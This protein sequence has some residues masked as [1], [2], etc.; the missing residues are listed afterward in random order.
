MGIEKSYQWR[1]VAE[2]LGLIIDVNSADCFIFNLNSV[3]YVATT[4]NPDSIYLLLQ[5]AK[6]MTCGEQMAM[7]DQVIPRADLNEP[8]VWWFRGH[9]LNG[10]PPRIVSL[11]DWLT[12][13][14]Y[15]TKALLKD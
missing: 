9:H 7:L 5:K 6:E 13:Q 15:D 10:Q 11:R 1:A 8:R 2:Q 3:G 4:K 12:E 14:G